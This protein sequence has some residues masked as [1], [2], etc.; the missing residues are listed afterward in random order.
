LAL[1][2]KNSAEC[3]MDESGRVWYN[4][5]KPDRRGLAAPVARLIDEF[6]AIPTGE[7]E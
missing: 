2:V 3:V 1:E 7:D 6:N 5:A 4:T